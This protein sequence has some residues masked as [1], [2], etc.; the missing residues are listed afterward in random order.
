MSP[1]VR[2]LI[3][4]KSKVGIEFLVFKDLI[5]NENSSRLEIDFQPCSLFKPVP[6]MNGIC[7][8][9]NALPANQVTI[10]QT[11]FLTMSQKVRPFFK[12]YSGF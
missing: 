4:L 11:F 7:Q 5:V 2:K 12:V 9:Y 8:S 6:T 3:K 10:L 1:F